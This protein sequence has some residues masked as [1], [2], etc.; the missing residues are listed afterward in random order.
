MYVKITSGSVETYPY[1]IGQLRRDNPS[2]SFPKKIPDDILESYGVYAVTR[3]QVPSINDRTQV[4]V[5]EVQPSLIN[6]TWTIGYTVSSKAAEE[7]QAYDDNKAI[8]N[9]K[10]RDDLLA[11]TDW[12][13]IMHTEKGTNIPADM[14]LYRQALRD[15]TSHANWPN[16]SDSDWP[17]KP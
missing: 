7:I 14:E 11:A 8:E 16:L 1:S 2:T 3:T 9:R 12:V 15:I 6:G 10:K 17:T 13:V 4:A 5:P